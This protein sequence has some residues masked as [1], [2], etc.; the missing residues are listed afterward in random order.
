MRSLDDLEHEWTLREI[1]MIE[2]RQRDLR[3]EWR[4]NHFRRSLPVLAMACLG[5]AAVALAVIVEVN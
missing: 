5:I 4:M 1:R 2:A 3:W